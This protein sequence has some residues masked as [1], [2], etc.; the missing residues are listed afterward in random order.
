MKRLN[1]LYAWRFN[2]R[3]GTRG[4]AYESRYWCELIESEAQALSTIRYIALNPVEAALCASPGAWPWSSYAATLGEADC[5][6]FVTTSWVVS[7]FGDDPVVARSELRSFVEGAELA[8][9]A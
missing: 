1:W 2:R 6:E 4:H 3:H 5:P 7:L 9:A 8:T